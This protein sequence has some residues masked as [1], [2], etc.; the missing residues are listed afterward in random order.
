MLKSTL[1]VVVDFSPSVC[2]LQSGDRH[3]TCFVSRSEHHLNSPSCFTCA[4]SLSVLIHDGGP[5]ILCW[6]PPAAALAPREHQRLPAPH[7]ELVWGDGVP[8]PADRHALCVGG[9][10]GRSSHPAEITGTPR[11]TQHEGSTRVLIINKSS[12]PPH[13][14]WTDVCEL[15]SKPSSPTC[16]RWFSPVWQEVTGGSTARRRFLWRDRKTATS[17]WSWRASWQGCPSTGSFTAPPPPSQW[18]DP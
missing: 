18:Y 1:G 12:S 7:Q 17:A 9:E 11:R 6:G 5:W 2:H 10:D 13:R 16:V 15:P 8:R 14:S 3:W 4:G